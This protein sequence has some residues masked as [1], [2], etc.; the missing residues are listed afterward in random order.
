MKDVCLPIQVPSGKYC[1]EPF[2]HGNKI[3]EHFSSFDDGE[4]ECDVGFCVAA[5]ALGYFQ[6]DPVC[7]GL[8]VIREDCGP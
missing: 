5:D 2:E 1:W 8:T 3:C 6:K 4:A 7:A